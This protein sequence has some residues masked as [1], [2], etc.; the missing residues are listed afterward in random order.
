MQKS[1]KV[2]D[3]RC[4]LQLLLL[5]PEVGYRYVA[6]HCRHISGVAGALYKY[7]VLAGLQQHKTSISSAWRS[8]LLL[9]FRKT[10]QLTSDIGRKGMSRIKIRVG[11]A[12]TS[13]DAHFVKGH[14]ADTTR[15][16]CRERL[17]HYW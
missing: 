7:N 5:L 11:T 10:L 14:L 17:A 15:R 16:Y 13:G 3:Q 1:E 8:L 4:G 2:L 12:G 6:T 9:G